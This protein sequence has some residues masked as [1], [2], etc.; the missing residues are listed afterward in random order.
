MVSGRNCLV[1]TVAGSG[2]TFIRGHT[3]CARR[4]SFNRDGDGDGDGN[5][6][7]FGGIDTSIA[8]EEMREAD[9]AA[10]LGR[11]IIPSSFSTR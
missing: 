11:K 7:G 3:I 2:G 4:Y 5:G 10:L 8:Q 6:D 1:R 9:S